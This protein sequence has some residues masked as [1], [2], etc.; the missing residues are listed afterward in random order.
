MNVKRKKK[1]EFESRYRYDMLCVS[2][3]VVVAITISTT[4][5]NG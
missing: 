1:K 2:G 5:Y 3:R 4:T